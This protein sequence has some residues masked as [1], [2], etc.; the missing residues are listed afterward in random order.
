MAFTFHYVRIVSTVFTTH[1][2]TLLWDW[3][4]ICQMYKNSL[5]MWL[6]LQKLTIMSHLANCILL[7]QLIPTLIHLLMHCCIDGFGWL[8]CFSGAGFADHVRSRLRQW[9]PWRALDGRYVSYIHLCVSKAS[10]KVLQA[11]LGLWLVV[12]GLIATLNNPIKSLNPPLASHLSP[13]PTHSHCPPLICA[14][15]DITVVVKKL[16]KI[17]QC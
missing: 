1:I 3:Q 17:L 8:V 6:D 14:I 4:L 12:L 15:C 16:L 13:P 9:G 5:K 7:A 10:L 11:S 2:K